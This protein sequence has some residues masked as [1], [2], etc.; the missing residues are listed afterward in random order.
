MSQTALAGGRSPEARSGNEFAATA[1]KQI[2]RAKRVVSIA[3]SAGVMNAAK[4]IY[5]KITDTPMDHKMRMHP[6]GLRFPIEMTTALSDIY[7]YDEVIRSRVYSLPSILRQRIN[8][9]PIVDMGAYIGLSAA[10]FASRHPDSPVLAVEPHDRNFRILSSNTAAYGGQ[11]GVRQA[12]FVSQEGGV[13]R[14][15]LESPDAHMTHLY[16]ADGTD[17]GNPGTIAEAMTPGRVLDEVDGAEIGLLK[18][19][20][21]GAERDVFGSTG[22]DELLAQ[23][24]LLMIETHDRFVP[25]SSDAVEAAVAN[26]GMQELAANPHTTVYARL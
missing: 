18:V 7:N 8:G 12:A 5:S 19:D 2:E 1:A 10:Y 22:I 3:R 11:I 26:N 4:C 24:Q 13:G 17:G 25:G 9:K 16:S 20:I 23:T 15:I 6:S 21:E 14:T